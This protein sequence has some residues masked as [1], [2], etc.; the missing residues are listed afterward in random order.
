MDWHMLRVLGFGGFVRIRVMG[1]VGMY[2][3]AV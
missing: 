2:G 3:S 1:T